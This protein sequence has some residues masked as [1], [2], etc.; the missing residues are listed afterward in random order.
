M[1]TL[2]DAVP[3]GRPA[4]HAP[5]IEA[6]RETLTNKSLDPAFV[7]EAVLLP[8]EAFIGDQMKEVDPEAIHRA[9][10]ALRADL[11]QRARGAVARRLCVERR[12]PLRI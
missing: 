2:I 6:V 5:V 10:E 11:G 12:Q 4:D 7:A 9:R 8:S 3:A 1:D